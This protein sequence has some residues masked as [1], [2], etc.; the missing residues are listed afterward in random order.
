MGRRTSSVILPAPS[1]FEL[2]IQIHGYPMVC[3]SI[4][5]AVH[6]VPVVGVVY[7][8]FL[9]LLVSPDL[10]VYLNAQYSGAKG[11]GSFLND[12]KLPIPSPPRPLPSFGQALSVASTK[13]IEQAEA[14]NWS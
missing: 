5:L 6:G 1:G 12:A 7:N 8:P 13:T 11:R 4:G 2:T 14:Q 10:S 9:E 3:T